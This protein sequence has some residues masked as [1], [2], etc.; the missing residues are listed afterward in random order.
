[1]VCGL[2]IL[3]GCNLLTYDGGSTIINLQANLSNPTTSLT[4]ENGWIRQVIGI[5]R[6]NYLE[7]KFNRLGFLARLDRKSE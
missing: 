5:D 7:E 1:M 3:P 2:T 4:V 6:L